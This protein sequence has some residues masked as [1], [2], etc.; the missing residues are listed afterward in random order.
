MTNP[1]VITGTLQV[2]RNKTKLVL[3]T[4]AYGGAFCTEYVTSLCSLMALCASRGI[5]FSFSQIDYADVTTS[6]NYLLSN[7]Y[8][9][10]PDA[11]FLLFVDS[12]M[13]YAA[14]LIPDMIALNEPLVGVVAPR[15]SVDLRALHANGSLPFA[16]AY[17]KSLSFIGRPEAPHPRNPNF[18]KV[19]AVGAG[20][21][22]IRRSAVDVMVSRVPAIVDTVRFR[23]LPFAPKFSQFLTPFDRVTLEDRWLSEDLSFCHRWTSLCGGQVYAATTYEI[24]HVARVALTGRWSDLPETA[25]LT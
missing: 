17:G 1:R 4:P 20:I 14:E 22:L 3:A 7:F 9:N 2:Q 6:R 15:R 11:E 23:R 13:G 21:L 5:G 25:R 18:M 10:K 8:Y 19:D 16:A 12:D 24:T